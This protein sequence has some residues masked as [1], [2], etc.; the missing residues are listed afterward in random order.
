MGKRKLTKK[1]GGG[2]KSVICNSD[3]MDDIIGDELSLI[4]FHAPWCGFCK[5]LKPEWEKACSN[6]PETIKMGK[7]DCDKNPDIA[8]RFGVTGFPTIIA[9][10][11]GEI[12][13]NYEGPHESTSILEYIDQLLR[14]IQ[15]WKKKKKKK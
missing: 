13:G 15:R 14:I 6:S 2:K 7:V 10:K 8:Q 5:K 12:I 4:N 11:D 3:N 9:F 1:R